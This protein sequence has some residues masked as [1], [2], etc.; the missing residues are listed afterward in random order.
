MIETLRCVSELDNVMS[1]EEYT[2]R[3][4]GRSEKSSSVFMRESLVCSMNGYVL[5]KYGYEKP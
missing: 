2:I 4:V 5:V 3:M 1:L